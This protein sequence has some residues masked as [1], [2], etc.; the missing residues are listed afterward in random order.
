M[1]SNRFLVLA[2]ASILLIG[3]MSSCYDLTAMGEDPYALPNKN[4]EPGDEPTNP[5]GEYV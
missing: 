3:G 2:M 4:T 5:A 1:K